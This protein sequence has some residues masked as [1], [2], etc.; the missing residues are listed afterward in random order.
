MLYSP[1]RP[2]R[3]C[4]AGAWATLLCA[5]LSFAGVTA[6]H[7][8]PPPTS[9]PSPSP[10]ATKPSGEIDVLG[11]LDTQLAN[12]VSD[13]RS[14]VVS[15]E[16]TVDLK[17]TPEMASQSD[18]PPGQAE[19]ASIR[20]PVTGSGFLLPG[21][22]VVTTAEVVAGMHDPAVILA[23]E[24]RVKV[25]DIKCDPHANVAI[26]RVPD[27]GPATGL[28]W[29]D[30][31][32]VRAGNLAI[33]IGNQAGFAESASLGMI[34]ATDQHARDQSRHYDHLIQFQGSLGIGESGSPLLNT[35]G[36]VIGMVIGMAVGP[37]ERMGGRYFGFHINA[38]KPQHQQT[39]AS[40]DNERAP[41]SPITTQMI[42]IGGSNMGF[43]LP[44]N[45]LKAAIDALV[46][47]ETR[48]PSRGWFGVL[49]DK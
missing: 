41:S 40:S 29:G 19:H 20:M 26:L 46:K 47:G 37:E 36:E 12:L 22:I 11:L 16:G 42:M 49:P 13:A 24:R 33:T 18:D 7:A 39:T 21:G 6:A 48:S 10:Q 5:L 45:Y 17:A 30:S 15:I 9:P 1:R 43:A 8:Q 31:L 28:R 27:A 32:D 2:I 23:A 25:S 34:S 3:P 4:R 38:S 35:R 14:A 44:S